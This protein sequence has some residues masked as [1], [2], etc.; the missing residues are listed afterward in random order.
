MTPD[1]PLKKELLFSKMIIII[2]RFIEITF[3]KNKLLN[4]KEILHLKNDLTHMTNKYKI[5]CEE[6]ENLKNEQQNQIEKL[7]TIK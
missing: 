6:H 1:F 3:V 7:N 2:K 5:K 4:E